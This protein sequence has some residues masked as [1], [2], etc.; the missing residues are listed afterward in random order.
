M[1]RGYLG[2][3][4]NIAHWRTNVSFI[5]TPILQNH[6]DMICRLLAVA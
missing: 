5:A 4:R 2:I 1:R 6:S 3:A